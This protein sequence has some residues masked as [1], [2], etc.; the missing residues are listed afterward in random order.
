M[1]RIG[2]ID[3]DVAALDAKAGGPVGELD[4]TATEA[5]R[6]AKNGPDLV[7]AIE[8][9]SGLKVRVLAGVEE[10]RY[11]TLGVIS[12]FFRPVGAVGDMG[13][14]SLE[15]ALALDDKVGEASVSLPLGALPVEAMLAGGREEAKRAIDDRLRD[16]LPITLNQPV[17]YAVGGGW[18]APDKPWRLHWIGNR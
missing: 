4:V 15:V 8:K 13:G 6:R 10:A 9:E 3:R 5:I 11:S 14:G 12:G 18:R 17:F 2:Q 16:E 1:R 7:A